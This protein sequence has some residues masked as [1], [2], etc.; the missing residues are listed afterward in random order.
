MAERRFPN[1]GRLVCLPEVE[2]EKKRLL[3]QTVFLSMVRIYCK[4]HRHKDPCDIERLPE[5]PVPLLEWVKR[6]RRRCPNWRHIRLCTSC[7][8]CLQLVAQRVD[9]CPHIAYKSFCHLCPTP[10]YPPQCTEQIVNIM[11]EIAPLLM[12]YHPVIV[13]KHLRHVAQNKRRLNEVLR[14]QKV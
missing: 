12:L 13:I 5:L 8:A 7:A 11:K 6:S 3:E 10:C 1:P 14:R 2:K 9:R 4:R